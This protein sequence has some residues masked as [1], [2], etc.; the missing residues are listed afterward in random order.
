MAA[1]NNVTRM[2]DAKK[3]AY[4][5][6]SVP[7]AKLSAL[8]VA[9]LLQVPPEHVYKTIVIERE[10][11]GKAILAIVPADAEVDLKKLAGA[12][13]E[14]KVMVTTQLRAESLTGL[15]AG[16]ISPLALIN[17]GFQL[18]L[19]E[20]AWTLEEIFISGGQWGLQ[21]AICPNDLVALTNACTA[22]IT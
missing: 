3:I 18:I 7:E 5:A 13:Q 6:C 22:E 9:G 1:A 11:K 14:K 8:E 21:I 19:D 10:K 4:R 17:K 15:K 12:L 2:L 16:G 20:K